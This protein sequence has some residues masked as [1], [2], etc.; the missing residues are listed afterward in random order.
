MPAWLQRGG[1]LVH[2]VSRFVGTSFGFLRAFLH[3]HGHS[4]GTA[5]NRNLAFP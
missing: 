2:T 3:Q 5:P 1:P 4:A